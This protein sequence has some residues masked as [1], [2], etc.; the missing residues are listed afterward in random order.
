MS[1]QE[2]GV[3][4]RGTGLD[5][6]AVDDGN[7]HYDDKVAVEVSMRDGQ[8]YV[9]R[10]EGGVVN[11][12]GPFMFTIPPMV[13]RYIQL[14][15]TRLEAV[16]KVTKEDGS[17]LHD[18]QDI[19]APIN[20]LAACMWERVDLQ[21]NGNPLSGGSSINAGYKAYMETLLSYDTDSA[22]SHL[23]T[24]LYY[25]D[26]PTKF[27]TMLA[28]SSTIRSAFYNAIAKGV[29]PRPTIPP[30][31]QADTSSLE[32]QAI[33]P[34]DYHYDDALAVLLNEDEVDT[35]MDGI[36]TQ[37][38]IDIA[39]QEDA[40]AKRMDEQRKAYIFRVTEDLKPKKEPD[41][42]GPPEGEELETVEQ[43][44][45]RHERNLVK[46]EA[47]E[48]EWDD[49][50]T[51][52]EDAA[53][54]WAEQQQLS[55]R[56]KRWWRRWYYREQCKK[57]L[58]KMDNDS[59]R[60]DDSAINRGFS[61]RFHICSGSA[62]F[63]T[64]APITHDFFKM[65]NNLGPGNRVDIRLTMYPHPFLLNSMVPGERYKLVIEDLL[66]HY[67]AIQ[68]VDRVKP[69]VKETYLLNETVVNKQI[70]AKD[71]PT[72]TFRIHNGGV[73]PKTIIFGMVRATAADGS[74]DR[75]PWNF[76]H[77]FLQRVEWIIN[78]EVYPQGG[79]K[80]K[81]TRVNP[82]TARGYQWVFDNSGASEGDQGNIISWEAFQA[83]SFIIPLDLTPDKCNSLH[84]H[85]AQYGFIDLQLTFERNTPCPLYVI[86]ETV[87]PKMLINDRVT[88]QVYVLDVEA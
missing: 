50:V 45:A 63:S 27:G 10:S 74:Y 21:L 9:I 25:N 36:D 66:L 84:H 58:A 71:V 43:A 5:V 39:K 18:C 72:I 48:Q 32:Y 3:G 34:V 38:L 53:R 64:M 28:S 42:E 82:H 8:D 56:Q 79:L 57:E 55:E 33:T 70:V 13:D 61:D 24:Q 78:G 16:L 51:A 35:N 7:F 54:R 23:H 6:T 29:Y 65:N 37:E 87:H 52:K 12:A 81:F 47:A 30:A 1:G 67:R 85:Q 46:I 88:N 60:K 31:F 20:L 76:H 62:S 40:T 41:L 26:T 11:Q 75:N 86:Y 19:V 69:P 4:T 49:Y 73:M 15:R 80:F 17:N 68:R 77:F 59:T 14:G 2:Y 44:N 22:N 83:G